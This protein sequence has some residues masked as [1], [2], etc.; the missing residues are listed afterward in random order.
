MR[1]ITKEINVYQFDELDK[2]IQEKVLEKRKQYEEDFYCE[3]TLEDDMFEKASDLLEQY[4]GKDVKKI[5][6]LYD[7]SYCQGCG[8][9]I[10]F[11]INIEDLNNKYNFLSSEELKFIQDKGLLNTITVKH[12]NGHYYHEYMFNVDY[13]YSDTYD[14]EDIKDFYNISEEEFSTIES[15]IDKF[16]NSFDKLNEPSVFA[17]DL[18]KINKELVQYGYGLMEYFWKDENVIEYCREEEYLS[19]GEIYYG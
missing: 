5:N 17:T 16:L 4:F 8:A 10:E 11:D 13:Y 9:M 6:V 15:R 3:T 1:K 12:N 7:L 2:D 14:Y 18:I 19:S